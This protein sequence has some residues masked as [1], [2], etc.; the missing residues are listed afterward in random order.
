MNVDSAAPL[1]KGEVIVSPSEGRAE[2]PFIPWI[3]SGRGARLFSMA[4][5][6][7]PTLLLTLILVPLFYS[8]YH[9]RTV[10]I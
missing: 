3:T 6:F 4:T 8:R 5:C 2:L 1:E 7:G 9:P 10:R